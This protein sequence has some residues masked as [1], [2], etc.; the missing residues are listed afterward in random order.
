MKQS[1]S[2]TRIL[3]IG[4]GVAMLYLW[5]WAAFDGVR[6]MNRVILAALVAAASVSYSV[7][8]ASAGATAAF[9]LEHARANARAGGPIS[10]Y[11]A[12]LLE[13]WG[14]ST[15]GPD[16][17]RQYYNQRRAQQDYDDEP[18]RVHRHKKHRRVYHD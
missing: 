12:E 4:F 3:F 5:R 8:P 18:V 15:G 2:F 16:W 17:R 11:D 7:V 13:R 6:R 1:L 14:N 10:E 9:E